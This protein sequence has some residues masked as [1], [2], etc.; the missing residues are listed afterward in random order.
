MMQIHYPPVWSL[1]LALTLAVSSLNSKAMGLAWFLVVLYGAWIGFIN[2][3]EISSTADY[4]W[5]KAWLLVATTSLAVKAISVFYWSDPWGER[6]G[7]LRLFLGALALYALLAHQQ[8]ERRRLAM[9][10]YSLTVSSTFGLI[11]VIIYGRDALPT[12]PIPWAGSMAMVSAFL[13]ALSLKSD[14]SPSHKRLWFMGGLLSAM[15]VLTSQSRGAYGI[16]LWWLVIGMHHFWHVFR[17]QQTSRRIFKPH[18]TR[19]WALLVA[20]VAGSVALSQTPVFQ[21]PAQSL[22]DAIEEVRVSSQSTAQGANSSVGARIYMWQK[23]LVAIYESPWMGHGHDTRK[24]FIQQWATEAQS[25]EIKRLGHVH[26]EYLHQ[27]IDHGL[28][29]LTSQVLLLVG[30]VFVALKLHQK[31]HHT[32]AWSLAGMAFIHMTTSL[33]NVNFAHNYYTA[34]LSFFIGLS[35]WLSRLETADLAHQKDKG[36]IS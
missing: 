36:A 22:Q 33:T 19:H 32:A 27:W 13:L 24:R 15:A 3:R 35:L 5:A 12:H 20:I 17:T 1:V 10:A 11:W 28:W 29:G 8:L 4:P 9:L 18:T 31:N 2:R 26:N 21:R 16:V 23:S 14:Y 25:D 7:E 30:L 6:H 34:S